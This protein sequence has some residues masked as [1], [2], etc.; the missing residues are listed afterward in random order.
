MPMYHERILLSRTRTGSDTQ[1]ATG[2]R[3]SAANP[4]S[5][6]E[7][8]SSGGPLAP[9]LAARVQAQR[10]GGTPMEPPTQ[11]RMEDGFGHNFADVRIHADGESDILNRSLG[12]RAFT[13]GSDIFLSREAGNAGA[14]GQVQLLAHELTHVV[15]QRGA[16]QVGPLTVGASDDPYEREATALATELGDGD[17]ASGVRASSRAH[18]GVAPMR[19]QRQGHGKGEPTLASLAE[20]VK[21]LKQKDEARVREDMIR[22]NKLNALNLDQY[23]RAKFNERFSSYKQAVWNITAGIQTAS[24]NFQAAQAA[25][26][27]TD[28][29]WAQFI[30]GVATVGFAVGFEWAFT[31]LLGSLGRNAG[32]LQNGIRRLSTRAQPKATDLLAKANLA[33]SIRVQSML[34]VVENPANAA[35]ASLGNLNA[36]D[37]AIESAAQGK[38]PAVQEAPGD[39]FSMGSDPVTFL[40]GNMSTLEGHSQAMEQAFVERASMME[41]VGV[42]DWENFDAEQQSQVYEGLYGALL[43]SGSGIE[44]LKPVDQ[45]ALIFEKRLWAHWLKNK[46]DFTR[47]VREAASKNS[48]AGVDLGSLTSTA[49]RLQAPNLV[50]D[51]PSLGSD[52]EQRLN[53]LGVADEAGVG[54]SGHFYE[55]NSDDWGAK[56]ANWANSYLSAGDTIV[57]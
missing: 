25:Q 23:W 8:N 39:P 44:R 33:E 19:V 1:P 3:S 42:Y 41:A 57:K 27:Q 29:M 12:A 22:D 37:T 47:T 45:I 55:R 10:G 30:A 28:Q 6:S 52:I 43:V 21:A 26:A 18:V 54:L 49:L 46:S 20:E 38:T 50:A 48:F 40:A 24:T 17:T 34:E 13:L 32:E 4:E 2:A 35:M 9:A 5:D 53:T 15:Q 51:M 7:V 56:L 11:Q 16:A 31:P 36:A 14:D